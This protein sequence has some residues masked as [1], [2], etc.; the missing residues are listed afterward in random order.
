MISMSD[1]TERE[2]LESEWQRLARDEKQA[3]SEFISV[4]TAPGASEA[5]VYQAWLVWSRL[6]D[7]CLELER[8]I[9][10]PE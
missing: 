3:Q 9:N 10:R 2:R 1:K 6:C 7:R 5:L 4:C 8:L